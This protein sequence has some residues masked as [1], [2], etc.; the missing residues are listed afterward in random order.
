MEDAI[1]DWELF[2]SNFDD[3]LEKV[4]NAKQQDKLFQ[5][6]GINI[7]PLIQIRLKIP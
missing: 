4:K 6:S 5:V 2:V 1:T 3:L 7:N